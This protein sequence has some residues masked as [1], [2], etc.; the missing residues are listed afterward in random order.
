[1]KEHEEERQKMNEI[2]RNA[3]ARCR[4]LQSAM[5]KM[6]IGYEA[7]IKKT[8]LE[9]DYLQSNTVIYHGNENADQ[10]ELTKL[11]KRRLAIQNSRK[12]LNE[13]EQY[14]SQIRRENAELNR[15][16]T[17]LNFT[18]RFKSQRKAV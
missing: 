3:K 11:T 10:Q 13:R 17:A 7:D 1:M 14:L 4:R 5:R 8:E 16:Y 9:L 12:V 2:Y 6:K 15:A 18:A